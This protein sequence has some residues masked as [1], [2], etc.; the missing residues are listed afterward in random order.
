MTQGRVGGV[1]S[2]STKTHSHRWRESLGHA[3]N[4]QEHRHGPTEAE[5]QISG[6]G[7]GVRQN[8]SWKWK[9]ALKMEL[10]LGWWLLCVAQLPKQTKD[11]GRQRR[12]RRST[13]PS[14]PLPLPEQSHGQDPQNRHCWE[15]GPFLASIWL[16]GFF[17]AGAGKSVRTE[18][19]VEGGH[20]RVQSEQA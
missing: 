16:S 11:R 2:L 6:R 8:Y 14:D 1:V 7:C 5:G 13:R 12:S 3:S 19:C 4:F 10:G 20:D 15:F 18:P 17:P 9:S